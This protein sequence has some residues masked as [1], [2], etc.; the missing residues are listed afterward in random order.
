[1]RAG[2]WH[3]FPEND[4]SENVCVCGA[5]MGKANERF[6]RFFVIRLA[7]LP[8]YR[9]VN[10]ATM[11]LLCLLL[12]PLS[13]LSCVNISGK[14]DTIGRKDAVFA[15][16]KTVTTRYRVGEKR[17]VPVSI[18]YCQAEDEWVDD[19]WLYQGMF[20]MVSG[21]EEPQG[22]E[23]TF[24]AEEPGDKR[25]HPLLTAEEADIAHAVIEQGKPVLQSQVAASRTRGS[26]FYYWQDPKTNRSLNY[27][28]LEPERSTG[29]R[30]R[31]P[32]CYVWKVVDVPLSA[33]TA[34]GEV[35]LTLAAAPICIIADYAQRQN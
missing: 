1:M 4:K 32:L 13:L 12:L 19:S 20:P 28:Y 23:V 35:V 22:R 14:W 6:V 15:P 7:P 27:A 30:L 21:G 9:K 34:A 8:S 25:Y 29:N 5:G 11:K 10:T 17:Y 31:R 3:N 26:I 18:R 33:V 2:S 24:Y 16:Q